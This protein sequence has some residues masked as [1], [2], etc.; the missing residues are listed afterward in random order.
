MRHD[1]S[2]GK[3]KVDAKRIQQIALLNQIGFLWEVPPRNARH[4]PNG[5]KVAEPP[6]SGSAAV[7]EA[8]GDGGMD[9]SQGSSKE[10]ETVTTTT[11]TKKR[12]AAVSLDD[13]QQGPL[14]KMAHLD[15]EPEEEEEETVVQVEQE[16]A[17]V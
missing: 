8:G 2:Y 1:K 3:D 11:T 4:F 6:A 13:G 10:N 14:K 15:P 7:G 16:K 17:S 12:P 9:D 5:E